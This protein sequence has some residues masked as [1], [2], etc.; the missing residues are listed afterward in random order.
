MA[1]SAMLI[2]ADEPNKT[3]EIMVAG[4]ASTITLVAI[5]QAIWQPAKRSRN[6]QAWS[7]KF[8]AVEDRCRLGLSGLS[9]VDIPDLLNEM[10]VIS[11]EADLIPE[12]RWKRAQSA[13]LGT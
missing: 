1:M 10:L 12:R 13:R 5:W 2:G 9:V 11:E 6:H 3:A 7:T 8:F 4:I